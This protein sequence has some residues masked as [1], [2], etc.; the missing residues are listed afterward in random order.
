MSILNAT[1]DTPYHTAPFSKIQDADYKPAFITAIK[2]ARAEIDA[3]TRSKEV[4]TFKNTIEALESI[5]R[6]IQI[7]KR[8]HPPSPLPRG[9]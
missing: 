9:N 8:K 7:L 1:F 3:I 6:R 4:A 5:L 2:K